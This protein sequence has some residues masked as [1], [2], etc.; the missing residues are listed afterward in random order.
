MKKFKFRL[1]KL[2]DSKIAR[3]D[4][5]KHELAIVV[6]QQ[7]VFRNKQESLKESIKNQKKIQSQ[8]MR[9]GHIS[10]S[11]LIMFDRYRVVAEKGIA[12]AQ[13]EIEKLEPQVNEIRQRLIDASK[14]R[15][16]IEKYKEKRLDEWK[17]EIKYAEEKEFDDINQKLFS[18][19]IFMNEADAPDVDSLY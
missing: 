15:K 1:Q 16:T 5:V 13:S 18:R 8:S 19:K 11:D 9:Q 14:E 3:E 7:N 4:A 17:K 2:L 10:Q 12:N 6:S